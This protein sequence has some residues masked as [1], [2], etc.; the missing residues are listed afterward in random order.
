[1]GCGRLGWRRSTSTVLLVADLLKKQLIA[2]IDKRSTMICLRAAGQI[3][4]VDE[5]FDTLMGFLDA[6]PFHVHCR[7]IV[8]PWMP[9][10]VSDI[11]KE[12]NA[13]IAN[14]PEKQ[15]R[16]GPDGYGG[17]LPPPAP[18]H[19]PSGP[20]SPAPATIPAP[21]DWDGVAPRLLQEGEGWK[22]KGDGL[23]RAIQQESGASGLPQLV[24]DISS[25]STGQTLLY[26]GLEDR[27]GVTAVEMADEFRSGPLFPGEGIFGNGTYTTT[28]LKSAEWYGD[29]VLKMTLP[30]TAKTIK[31]D[32]LTDKWQEA[33][34]AMPDTP[35]KKLAADPGRWAAMQGYDA[36][37]VERKN[38]SAHYVVLNRSI[39]TVERGK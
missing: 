19:S 29:E 28:S 36:I 17:R 18:G 3:Q 5:P 8:V 33:M 1:M 27:L 20:S 35:V 31:Y 23:L 15:K 6:P 34:D 25:V 21:V 4:P 30:N 38:G 37:I 2:V 13:E 26:R 10:F 32:D 7:S 24:D 12:A 11:R 39:L 22:G 9:G 16:F 14:R